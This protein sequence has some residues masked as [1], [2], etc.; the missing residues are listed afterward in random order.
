MVWRFSGVHILFLT[1]I[2]FYEL[3]MHVQSLI[4]PCPCNKNG[5]VTQFSSWY[6]T[7]NYSQQVMHFM[8]EIQYL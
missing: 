6:S 5:F 3:F 4:I 7:G 8:S 1:I 2:L